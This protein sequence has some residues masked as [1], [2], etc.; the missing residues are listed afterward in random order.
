MLRRIPRERV[1]S[2]VMLCN[3]RPVFINASTCTILSSGTP[4]QLTL[5][6]H[7]TSEDCS[8][9]FNASVPGELLTSVYKCVYVNL[10]MII[11]NRSTHIELDPC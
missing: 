4:H 8:N 1:R 2:Y 7:H 3:H 5:H 6:R 11:C 10:E 9:D